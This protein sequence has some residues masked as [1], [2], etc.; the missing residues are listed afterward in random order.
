V[1]P[2]FDR[3]WIDVCGQVALTGESSQFEYCV[4]PLG[5][6]YDFTSYSPQPGQVSTIIWEIT[7]RKQSEEKLRAIQELLNAAGRVAKIGGFEVD[8][9]TLRVTW[10]EGT[11]RLHGL[12]LDDEPTLE[13]AL[14]FP[15]PED[16][17]KMYAAFQRAHQYGEPCDIE[18]RYFTASGHQLWVRLSSKSEMVDGKVVKIYGAIQDVTEQ[19][20]TAQ[21]L[22]E[23][24]EDYRQLFEA[25]SDAI[26]LLDKE[27]GGIL[28]ANNAAS[29]LY[30]YSR[31][32][33]ITM[34]GF[35]LSADPE[36]ARRFTQGIQ[37]KEGQRMTIP[38]RYHRKKDE[39]TF[40]VEITGRL[41]ARHGRPVLISAIRDITERKRQEQALEESRE[42]YRQLFEAESD[43]IVL[44][45]QETGD[46]AA[47]NKAASDLYGYS[48]EELINMNGLDLDADPEEARH[49]IDGLHPQEGQVMT[50]LPRYHRKK[51]GTAFPV[52][53]MGRFFI[54]Y[55]RPVLLAAVRDV[56]ERKKAEKERLAHQRFF[57]SMDRVSRAIQ[58][59]NDL[60][61]MMSDVLDAL[62]TIFDCDRAW[63]VYPCDPNADSWKVPMERTRPEY[64]GAL[65][66]GID[67]PMTPDVVKSFRTV[68]D[69]YC[70]VKF[71]P[72]ADHSLPANDSM[73]FGYQSFIGMA[74]RPKTDKPYMF[75]LHQCSYPRVWTPEEER[76]FQE[77]G[78]RLEDALTNLLTYRELRESEEKF[79][80]LAASA[81]D[82][83]FMID[84]NG[85]IHYWNSAA[86]RIFGWSTAEI[87][88]KDFHATLAPQ[89]YYDAFT[90]GLAEFKKSGSGSAFSKMLELSACRKNGQEFPVELGASRIVFQG[91]WH[92]ICIV[93]DITERKRQGQA[94]EESREDYRQLFE[95]ESD[96][97][98]LVDQVTGNILAANSAA[99]DL[100]GYSHEELITLTVYDLDADPE[101]GK[102]LVQDTHLEPG[103]VMTNVPRYHLKKDGTTVPVEIS[104]RF[105]IR[106]G[107][108]CFIAAFR[109]ITER[110]RQEQALEESRENYRQLFEAESDAIVLVDRETG[111]ILAANNTASDLYGY[112]HEELLTMIIY[113]LDTDPEGG[114]RLVQ[115]THLE[116]GQVVTNF[117]RYHRK[118]DGTTVP[119]EIT[120]RFF[121]R[122]GRPFLLGAFRDVTEHKRQEEERLMLEKHLQHVQKTESLD[123]MAGAVAHHFNNLL[124]VVLGNLELALYTQA[125]GLEL[126][127]KIEKA[128]S[129]SI[130]AAEISRLMLVYLGQNFGEK[131]PMDL[132]A[133]CRETEPLLTSSL[134]SK[135]YLKTV[136]PS[137]GPI[138]MADSAQMRQVLV[139]LI[140]NAGEAM[141]GMEGGV[142]TLSVSIVPAA[143][144]P[145]S[146]SFLPQ[147][148][149]KAEQYGCLEISDTGCGMDSETLERIFDPFFS[150]KFTGR[151]LGLPVVLGLVKTFG[152]TVIVDSTPGKGTVFQVFLPIAEQEPVQP[153]KTAPIERAPKATRG[154]VLVVDDEPTL[155][156]VAAAMLIELG[157]EVVMATDGAE[158]L[159]VFREHRDRM[160]CV[161]LDLTMPRMNGWETLTALRALRPE[162]PVILA[163]GYDEVQVMA[164]DHPVR[165][166]AFLHKPYGMAGLNAALAQALGEGTCA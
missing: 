64:P 16:R 120:A 74:L 153:R 99:S 88:G 34:N 107:Q 13:K 66:L 5:R 161:L 41:F 54:R 47:V 124:G 6:W 28:A 75:G 129:A 33:L 159:E 96:A 101:G 128:M 68:S 59:T 43:A 90:K 12:P 81:Q 40:P 113:D 44:I 93:R 4:P 135:V 27:T 122:C 102:R 98:V 30:G 145:V 55:G 132:P 142:I 117:P 147:W 114:K 118:K 165:P 29:A 62:L 158:A 166:Q 77:I 160:Q 26:V 31:E 36:E 20:R 134:P 25:I 3:H 80:S 49:I 48:H 110:K 2:D 127:A 8:A 91:A 137:Q 24:S 46:I 106:Y 141:D 65:A 19:K 89:R 155:R 1:L 163:S 82:A 100:Y 86:E 157:C 63:L 42:D 38:L 84:S 37:I 7:K 51:D 45:D 121:I 76:L 130:R 143:D 87:L 67:I 92:A 53:V 95:A 70:P 22:E 146:R 72:S 140:T 144:I 148:Q 149:P 105:F 21:A 150:T 138:I 79:K 125:Q 126:R 162:L 136:L 18:M 156:N 69:S 50:N 17:E 139:N 151:G 85:S 109:D 39:S 133:L 61:Q 94:L 164:G 9:E 154:L 32:E 73:R 56:T 11:Y 71:G 123:R 119:V 15:H 131:A 83:I 52:E 10:T 115:D 103:Q 60:E 78:R 35:D 23:S 108:P 112:S 111:G 104:A 58:G 57:E 14:T 152:G 97:I 116:P